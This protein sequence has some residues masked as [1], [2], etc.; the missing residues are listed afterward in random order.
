V[1]CRAAAGTRPCAYVGRTLFR[2]VP[3]LKR[4][5]RYTEIA[6]LLS[7]DPRLAVEHAYFTSSA[8]P[9]W[10][11]TVASAAEPLWITQETLSLVVLPGW[12]APAAH[13]MLR[14]PGGSPWNVSTTDPGWINVSPGSGTGSAMLTIEPKPFRRA[15]EKTVTVRIQ[16][17]D[18]PGGRQLD[19]RMRSVPAITTAPSGAVDMPPESVT[20]SNPPVTFQGWAL[21]VFN[22]RRVAV[23]GEDASGRVMTIGYAYG[24]IPRPDLSAVFPGAPGLAIAGWRFTVTPED[25]AGAARPL[26]VRFYAESVDG[27]RAE[28][29]RRT[30]R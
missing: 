28:I 21:D 1:R 6:T 24:S 5:G 20:L 12:P 9:R 25:V 17:N 8:D 7:G 19:V 4:A 22:L 11:R 18:P 2:F 30:I 15:G 13:V 23:A 29:G 14:D 26:T 27:R 16:V 3:E 10:W